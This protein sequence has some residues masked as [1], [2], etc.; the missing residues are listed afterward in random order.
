L[1]IKDE[2]IERLHQLLAIKEKTTIDLMK[3]RKAIETQLDNLRNRQTAWQKLKAMFI[4]STAIS[5][6]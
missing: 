4:V 1:K 3:E 2:Q 6:S 5:Q